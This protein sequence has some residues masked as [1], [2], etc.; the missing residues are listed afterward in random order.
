MSSSR[1]DPWVPPSWSRDRGSHS[2]LLDVTVR[3]DTFVLVWEVRRFPLQTCSFFKE[4]EMAYRRKMNKRKSR[5]LFSR[6]GSRTH[7]KNLGGRPM[8]GGIRL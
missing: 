1:G 8:R 2:P 5:K 4:I 7:K 6:T 3:T